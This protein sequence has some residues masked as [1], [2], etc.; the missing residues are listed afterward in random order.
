MREKNATLAVING[1]L[2]E[3]LVRWRERLDY[4]EP[5][6]KVKKFMY[7]AEGVARTK[8]STT[9]MNCFPRKYSEHSHQRLSLATLQI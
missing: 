6:E 7:C 2:S 3:E 4:N 5:I 8:Q 1:Q 9:S